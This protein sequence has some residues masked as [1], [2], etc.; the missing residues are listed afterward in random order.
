MPD[1]LTLASRRPAAILRDPGTTTELAG[2]SASIHRVHELLRRAAATAHS[3]L[4]VAE[5]GTDV[6]SIAR[7][8]HQ[9]FGDP[10]A[11]FVA[12]DCSSDGG[13]V[14]TLLFGESTADD[15]ELEVIAADGRLAEAR[16]G[17]L[18]LRDIGELP[19]SVQ[20]RL[21]RVMRDG[22][23]S[24]AGRPEPMTFRLIAGATPGIDGDAHARRFR[25]DLFRR[26]SACRIDVPPLR[27]R[28]EDIPALANRI[29][30]DLCQARN[31]TPRG[32]T[33]AALALLSALPWPGNLADLQAVLERVVD[34]APADLIQI[35]HLFPAIPLDRAPVRFVPAGNLKEARLRFERE[36]IAAVLQHHDWKIAEAAQTLGIQR[37]N[38]YRKAR[39]LGITL[40]RVSDQTSS[41]A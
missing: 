35:E 3:V 11:R 12:V 20:G 27:D 13:R 28:A 40:T 38:L 32:F 15:R 37:S 2:R 10:D 16:G 41:K 19:A 8:L 18:F 1:A 36:Y 17:T 21:A 22:E 9:R 33:Q 30:E 5:P 31:L 4:L 34:D 29:L 39:Q 26:L 6:E 24:M 14:D 7:D 25:P 23:A